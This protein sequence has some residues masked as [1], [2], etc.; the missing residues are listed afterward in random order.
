MGRGGAGRAHRFICLVFLGGIR[1]RADGTW[2][3][4]RHHLIEAK[5]SD[6]TNKRE[7]MR[8]PSLLAFLFSPSPGRYVC[9]FL[10]P[11]G[12]VPLISIL[13]DRASI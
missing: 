7:G 11:Q 4:C 3:P 12:K 5:Q 6:E 1:E 13:E 10:T 2:Y 9:L 8:V